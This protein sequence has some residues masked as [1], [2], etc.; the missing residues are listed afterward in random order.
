MSKYS[1]DISNMSYTNK[2]FG[3]IYPELLEIAQKL[4]YKWDP[5]TSD[6]SDPGVVLLK[7]AAIIADKNNYNIDKNILETFP[8]SVTQ[9]ETARQLY[10]QLGYSMRHY[11]SA[12]T[13]ISIALNE[14]PELDAEMLGVD[15]NYLTNDAW[16][17]S[18]S[19]SYDI[20]RF[21]MI[22]DNS[23]EIVYTVTEP[24][25]ISS[26]HKLK[27]FP[28]IQGVIQSYTVNNDPVI[29]SSALDYE[30]R[31]YFN[32]TNVAENG[33]FIASAGTEDYYKWYAV[34]N[35]SIQPMGSFCYKFGVSPSDG[36]CYI[37]FPS[38]AENLIGEGIVLKYVTS[39]GRLG[40]VGKNR[41]KKFFSDTSAY[42][43]LTENGS[44]TNANNQIQMTGDNVTILNYNSAND[45]RD[46]ET[47][48][49]AYVNYEKIKTTFD[50]LVSLS[51][52][53]NYMTR[54][55]FDRP[56]VSNGF[57]C[58]RTN[59]V[60]SSYKVVDENGEE[61]IMVHSSLT[62]ISDRLLTS[63]GEKPSST[64]KY[65][66]LEDEMTAFDLKI[67][68][69]QYSNSVTTLSGF[70]SS[71][72]VLFD[73]NN[74]VFGVSG[75]KDS[76]Q[77][78]KS[79]QHD[80][81]SFKPGEIIILKN[82]YP[83][84]VKIVP[85]Y[86]VDT[87]QM[88]DI[89]SNVRSALCNTLNAK[90]LSFGEFPDFNTVYDAIME[91]DNRIKAIILDEFEYET[92]AVYT[93]DNKTSIEV[94][95]D[96]GSTRPEE[97]TDSDRTSTM[98]DEYWEK[99]KEYSP[100]KMWIKFRNDVYVRSIL[101]GVT[102]LFPNNNEFTYSLEQ[103]SQG[104]YTGVS[105][106][107]TNLTLGLATTRET[108]A[109]SVA[110]FTGE[111]AVRD[112]ESVTFSMPS[113][114]KEQQ[115]SSYVKYLINV[116]SDNG[117]DVIAPDS[118]YELTGNDFIIF[119]W[120]SSD[121][122]QFYTYK[123]YTANSKAKFVC[124]NIY[125][126]KKSPYPVDGPID[127]TQDTQVS[128][129]VFRNLPEGKGTTL[130][131]G[132]AVY[133]LIKSIAGDKGVLSGD[134]AIDMKCPN[135]VHIN[136]PTD[137][138]ELITWYLNSSKEGQ[139]T[140]LFEKN[141]TK[142]TLQNGESFIYSNRSKS[143]IV[144]LGAGT[145]IER[146]GSRLD[147]KWECEYFDYSEF[148]NN[149][150]E[151]LDTVA[152]TIPNGANVYAH[153]MQFY[154]IGP[155]NTIRLTWNG[156][157][158]FDGTTSWQD[159][160]DKDGVTSDGYRVYIKDDATYC[161]TD[162]SKDGYPFSYSGVTISYI[163][164]SGSETILPNRV[165]ST[166]NWEAHAVLNVNCSP[167]VAQSIV[168]TTNDIGEIINSGDSENSIRHQ[169]L[170]LNPGT[171]SAQPIN[172]STILVSNLTSVYGG[173]LVD[174]SYLD[175]LTGQIKPINVF[176]FGESEAQSDGGSSV[177]FEDF[178]TRITV[179]KFTTGVGEQ[180]TTTLPVR[181]PQGKYILTLT[182]SAGKRCEVEASG[183]GLT[184][185]TIRDY[186]DTPGKAYY[187]LIVPDDT[188]D[189]NLEI[190]CE[191]IKESDIIISIDS[192]YKT[193]IPELPIGISLTDTDDYAGLLTQ[194]NK[195][196]K[197]GRYSLTYQVPS[198][199]LI[200]NPLDSYSFSDVGHPYNYSTICEWDVDSDDN[201][202]DVTNKIK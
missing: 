117:E 101:A 152:F 80:F 123:K 185:T 53:T 171:E 194:I 107:T 32:D 84:S 121:K 86:K 197:S 127:N 37:E 23:D 12:E 19:R 18:K 165:S 146:T 150:I 164:E 106:I 27:D 158:S 119:F 74:D 47:L 135:T 112:N 95:I 73:D 25:T 137:G 50:T 175:M 89:V 174:V 48:E 100:H 184:L 77:K 65:Y 181:V 104:I 13:T 85:Q 151:Y 114:T 87:Q 111:V 147:E 4:S 116:S 64:S 45:G 188:T 60:Q 113:L 153:E 91:S 199:D 149:P 179:E 28:A 72:E 133:T 168:S 81:K 6:E 46:P 26:D 191:Q 128:W 196:D 34:D 14:E 29:M 83:I 143:H 187:E 124:P 169:A 40:N 44:N 24:I 7:L 57:V 142:Y 16:L 11:I 62:D 155:G 120:K 82:K 59:D 159:K 200:E 17:K 69:L 190:S 5:T 2:D 54:Q 58:D 118:E 189:A 170:T 157:K 99:L 180:K 125:L 136:S 193:S 96:Y 178:K 1:T 172:N 63:E 176:A 21:T 162:I 36:R 8:K 160:Y 173:S 156:D 92:Y 148:V 140:V 182:Q 161:G 186:T 132:N 98:S 108:N 109:D 41:L 79:I 42:V 154:Q 76:I 70:K 15:E 75:Y 22:S 144:A 139:K 43:Y 9:L 115:Y 56:F 20:P 134:S 102:P 93:V 3:T 49:E 35:L 163:D 131:M 145:V 55:D 90:E 138:Y 202:I 88:L 52:Y 10:E 33:I 126:D 183:L 195:L 177:I 110:H 201:R 66:V 67:Y 198:S 78:I 105:K 103:I 167:T 94:R 192:L 71:F 141:Q 166:T 30:N 51:D 39:L 129:E 97:L 122:D 38:D 31:L 68:A 130:L 61:V